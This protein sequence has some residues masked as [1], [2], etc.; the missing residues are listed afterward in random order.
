[1]ET[2]NKKL[3]EYQTKLNHST[4]S[5]SKKN[6]NASINKNIDGEDDNLKEITQLMKKIWDD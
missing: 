3:S 5:K 2:N 6:M 4:I 1:M